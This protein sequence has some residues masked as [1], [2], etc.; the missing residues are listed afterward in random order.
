MCNEAVKDTTAQ[1]VE[2]NKTNDVDLKDLQSIHEDITS[3]KV[4]DQNVING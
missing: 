3:G 1:L 4:V 2:K